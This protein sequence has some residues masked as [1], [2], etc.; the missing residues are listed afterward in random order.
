MIIILKIPVS[1][2]IVIQNCYEVWGQKWSLPNG[3]H[4]GKSLPIALTASS[5]LTTRFCFFR[6]CTGMWFD[7]VVLFLENPFLAAEEL[8]GCS[9]MSPCILLPS[10]APTLKPLSTAAH[11]WRSSG[12]KLGVSKRAV[13]GHR[14]S[15]HPL[16]RPSLWTVRAGPAL[17]ASCPGR[18]QPSKSIIN[19]DG[20]PAAGSDGGQATV[21][22][23]QESLR[24]PARG[25]CS[26]GVV[27]F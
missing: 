5:L 7:A 2:H 3:A 1:V 19:R 11:R 26:L 10:V 17:W 23:R 13:W 27:S 12:Q 16:P 24:I 25:C 18:S 15:S 14:R 8:T 4:S 22:S 20:V 21:P 6:A 9:P